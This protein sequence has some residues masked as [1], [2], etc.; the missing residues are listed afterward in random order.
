M[1]SSIRGYPVP[2]KTAVI[3][4][5]DSG[6][7]FIE[8]AASLDGIARYSNTRIS[9]RGTFRGSKSVVE[10][11]KRVATRGRWLFGFVFAAELGP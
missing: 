11:P 9:E 8:S 10:R 2:D 6:D 1:K 3:T 4:L 5:G 7:R